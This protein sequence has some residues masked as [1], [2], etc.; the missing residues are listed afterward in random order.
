MQQRKFRENNRNLSSEEE[1]KKRKY[2]RNQ[3]R[4]LFVENEL[5]EQEKN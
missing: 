5:R 2:A 1:N 4:K 3:Y